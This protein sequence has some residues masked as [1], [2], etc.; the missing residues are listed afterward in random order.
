MLAGAAVIWRLSWTEY[1]HTFVKWTAWRHQHYVL[2]LSVRLHQVLLQWQTTSPFQWLKRRKLSHIILFLTLRSR[3]IHV[4]NHWSPRQREKRTGQ[5]TCCPIKCPCWRWHNHAPSHLAC[6]KC[7]VTKLEF[8]EGRNHFST[9]P[10]WER[11][12]DVVD[13]VHD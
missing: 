10:K 1:Q 12:T 11:E 2:T 4:E 13:S 8:R 3:R 9:L 6:W 7:A 5:S